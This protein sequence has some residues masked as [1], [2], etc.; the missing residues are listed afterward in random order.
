VIGAHQIEEIPQSLT[1]DDAA[2]LMGCDTAAVGEQKSQFRE[3]F[4]IATEV[5]SGLPMR[6]VA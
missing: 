1:L 2:D 4:A 6:L 3:Q 5:S